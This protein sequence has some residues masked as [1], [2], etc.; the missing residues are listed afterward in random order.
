MVEIT[1]LPVVAIE[2]TTR[3]IRTECGY[4]VESETSR[5]VTISPDEDWPSDYWVNELKQVS[6]S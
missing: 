3:Y 1:V 5:E 6:F 2:T 4:E